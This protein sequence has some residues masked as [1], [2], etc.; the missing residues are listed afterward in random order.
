MTLFGQKLAFPILLAPAGVHGALHSLGEL[1]TA[2]GATRA[3]TV[4]VIPSSPS[5]PVEEIT[6][7]ATPPPWYQP[8]VRPDRGATR[9]EAQRT[10]NAG[11]KG[12]FVT[13]DGAAPGVPNSM[14][15]APF[16]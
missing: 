10:E 9:E 14:M 2:S 13:V 6:R 11:C 15:R 12:L 1:E 7:L 5:R 3:Q 4:L 16:R 8:Y